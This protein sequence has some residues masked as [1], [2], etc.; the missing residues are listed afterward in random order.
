MV[1]KKRMVKDG[2][3]RV[4][5][6]TCGLSLLLAACIFSGCATTP[7]LPP[8]TLT[9]TGLPEGFD[10]KFANATVLSILDPTAFISASTTVASS[11]GTAITGGEVKLP[12]YKT[13][14]FS[15]NGYGGSDTLNV[16]FRIFGKLEEA[17]NDGSPDAIF[18]P[19]KF[20]NGE[21]VVNWDNAVKAGSI[22]VT[23]IPAEY[24]GNNRVPI[25]IDYVPNALGAVP[26]S[27]T[28]GMGFIKDGKIT[29]KVLCQR[30]NVSYTETG[31]RD[32]RISLPDVANAGTVKG[33]GGAVKF[34][35]NVVFLFKSAQ[36]T[37]GKATLDFATGVKEVKEVKEK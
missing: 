22:T 12:L 16:N 13:A 19:V 26:D 5:Q 8:G 35:G 28:W 17:S 30:Q 20:E 9:I 29:A 23:G 18:G 4:F 2:L 14:I 33:T 37:D 25:Y 32:I 27:V 11:E 7:K 31:T 15:K 36:I 6:T 34:I 3:K 1:N 10:G 24:S 21:A